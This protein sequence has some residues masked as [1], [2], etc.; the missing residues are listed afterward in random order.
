MTLLMSELSICIG[1]VICPYDQFSLTPRRRNEETA[2]SPRQ[3]S[4]YPRFELVLPIEVVM[5]MGGEPS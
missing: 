4:R 3:R 2:M 5:W 1:M